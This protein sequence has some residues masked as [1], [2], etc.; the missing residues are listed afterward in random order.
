MRDDHLRTYFIT[1]I[2]SNPLRLTVSDPVLCQET[3]GATESEVRGEAEQTTVNQTEATPPSTQ[4]V[5]DEE[6]SAAEV[7]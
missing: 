6:G 4:E 5:D 7:K 3:E 2:N 1:E